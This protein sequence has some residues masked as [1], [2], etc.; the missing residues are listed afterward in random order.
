MNKGA[1]NKLDYIKLLKAVVITFIGFIQIGIIIISC[2][3]DTTKAG[4]IC[5][6]IFI[7]EMLI[8]VF[9]I[10]VMMIYGML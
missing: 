1:G 9:S 8:L 3:D 5:K 4:D 2:E 6:V 7:V 10:I